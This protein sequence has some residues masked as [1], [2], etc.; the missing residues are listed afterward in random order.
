MGKIEKMI[1][2][3]LVETDDHNGRF[4]PFVQLDTYEDI[5]RYH[6][7]IAFD[8]ILKKFKSLK[9]LGLDGNKHGIGL[10]LLLCAL[11]DCARPEHQAKIMEMLL[12]DEICLIPD[13]SYRNCLLE[14]IEKV[15]DISIL[16]SLKSYAEKIKNIPY[17]IR[18]SKFSLSMEMLRE[19]DQNSVLTAM[20]ACVNNTIK[21]F[22]Y[23]DKLIFIKSHDK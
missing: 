7:D 21:Q 18:T 23:E 17:E 6:E 15:G 12:W 4:G 19:E 3:I 10:Y 22:P 16:E 20:D 14:A 1:D 8:P 2:R 11:R 9:N 5:V 13:R